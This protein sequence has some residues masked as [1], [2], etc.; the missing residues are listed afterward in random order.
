[1]GSTRWARNR[2]LKC[3]CGGYWFPH[4]RGGGACDHS[5]TRDIHLASRSRD[6]D[7]FIN[8]TWDASTKPAKDC[9]F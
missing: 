6:Q 3:E 7:A 8:A 9:P 1:M 5:A 4:R 2:R